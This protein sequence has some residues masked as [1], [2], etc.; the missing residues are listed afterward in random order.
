MYGPRQDASRYKAVHLHSLQRKVRMQV[1]RDEAYPMLSYKSKTDTVSEMPEKVQVKVLF[2]RAR[3]RAQRRQTI[4]LYRLRAELSPQSILTDSHEVAFTPAE[5]SLRVLRQSIPLSYETVES[6]RER[7]FEEP[8]E[9]PV[10]FLLQL[11]LESF[12]PE[13][14]YQDATRDDLHLRGVQQDVQSRLQVQGSRVATF[15]S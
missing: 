2:N 13:R 9:F 6:Y 15:E 8:A 5:L 4:L 3:Q 10:P 1:R 7:A 14:A 12:C 11:I